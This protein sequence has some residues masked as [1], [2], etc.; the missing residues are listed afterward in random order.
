M[1]ASQSAPPSTH[2]LPMTHSFTYG[3][4][5]QLLVTR[6]PP[7][8]PTE[9]SRVYQVAWRKGVGMGS[10]KQLSRNTCAMYPQARSP[11]CGPHP[12]A[13][14]EVGG[15]DLT[16]GENHVTEVQKGEGKVALHQHP[17]LP[18]PSF[19]PYW[20]N[21]PV[22]LPRTSCLCSPPPKWPLINGRFAWGLPIGASE[23][24]LMEPLGLPDR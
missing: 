9:L 22:L 23:A 12:P 15:D 24:G 2:T 20:Q 19:A 17:W 7:R 14:D 13:G 6:S 4:H 18:S 10:R 21:V 8:V 5:W 1:S 3:N 16:L 11:P